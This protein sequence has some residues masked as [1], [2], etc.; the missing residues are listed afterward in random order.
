MAGSKGD[1]EAK[2]RAEAH[3]AQGNEEYK[4]GDY[5]AAVAH[6]SRAIGTT[7]PSTNWSV[8]GVLDGGGYLYLVAAVFVP[9][10]GSVILVALR[11]EEF[12]EEPS[13]YGNR[14]AS[15]MMEGEWKPA[16]DDALKATQLDPSFTKVS[17][18]PSDGMPLFSS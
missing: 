17:T 2:A 4:K 6:Y 16:L 18:L 9:A 7:F 1:S 11:A 14:A 15:R 13:Y 3:K 10:N 5:A 12:P 8:L